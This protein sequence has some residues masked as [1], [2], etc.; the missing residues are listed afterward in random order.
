METVGGPWHDPPLMKPPQELG[1]DRESVFADP[2]FVDLDRGDL[3]LRDDS[4]ALALGFVPFEVDLTG[5]QA[6]IARHG[7]VQ[8]I[9]IAAATDGAFMTM[10]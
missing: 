6:Y 10:E 1:Y 4:P 7:G 8:K 5:L 2:R 3:R 9:D